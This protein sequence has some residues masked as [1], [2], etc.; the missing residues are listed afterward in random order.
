MQQYLEDFEIM[1]SKINFTETQ[2][3]SHFLG[4]LKEGLEMSVRLFNPFTLKHTYN[5]AKVLEVL[6]IKKGSCVQD[7][8]SKMVVIIYNSQGS[9]KKKQ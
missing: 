7:T 5:I 8:D 3:I 6:W 2:A 1:L 4:E 9:S